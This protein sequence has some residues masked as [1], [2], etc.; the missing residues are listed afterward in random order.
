MST[1]VVRTEEMAR[2][3]DIDRVGDR[4]AKRSW[5]C[6]LSDD[7]LTAAA[8]ETV[9]TQVIAA[10]GL[11]TWGQQHP[12][13]P[14]LGLRKYTL[15]ERFGDSPYHIQIV[16]EYG[17]L[18]ANDLL[19]PTAQTAQW[20]FEATQGQVPA[21]FYYP[22]P[23]DGSGNNTRYPLTNSAYDYFE[24]L[25]TEEGMT[26]ATMKK[27]YENFPTSLVS[28]T[29]SINDALWFG[30]PTHT[31]KITGVNAEYTVGFFNWTVVTYWATTVQLMYRQTGW[32]LQLPDVGW[33][34]IDGGEK[35]RAMVFDFKNGEWVASPNPVALSQGN[36]V[37]TG[38]P[39]ILPRRVNP[40]TNFS[41]LFPEVPA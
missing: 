17:L 4:V 38:R 21:L 39:D 16:A 25:V 33:N 40:E 2:E 19:T 27:N 22:D 6:T 32:K 26:K 1:T 12:E 34:F 41:S 30:G 35:R 8:V 23:P 15:T 7:T 36:I 29:N 9:A 10:A 18:T 11:A 37:I 31:W 3:Y 13:Y 24:G 14:S 5:V 20:S 28:N